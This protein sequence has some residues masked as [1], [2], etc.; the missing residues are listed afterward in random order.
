M[1]V[2]LV[3]TNWGIVGELVTPCPVTGECGTASWEV[4]AEI[5]L[6]WPMGGNSSAANLGIVTGSVELAV[7]ID[8]DV[9]VGS[10]LI[11]PFIGLASEVVAGESVWAAGMLRL[12]VESVWASVIGFSCFFRLGR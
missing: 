6:T 9:I 3:S 8:C 1:T 7:V 11:A 2:E 5:M 12:S 10:M 4:V